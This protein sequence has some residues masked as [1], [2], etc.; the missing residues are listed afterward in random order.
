[1]TAQPSDGHVMWSP[2]HYW[3]I[4]Q[5]PLHVFAYDLVGGTYDLV[6][7][8]S[9]RLTLAKPFPIDLDLQDITP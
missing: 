8:S 3:R 2:P 1:M 9:E 7:D 5:G 6:A 4:E